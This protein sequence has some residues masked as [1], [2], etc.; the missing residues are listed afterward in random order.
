MS[1]LLLD[2]VG[3]YRVQYPQAG[4]DLSIAGYS[5][6]Q[7]KSELASQYRELA[8]ATVQVAGNVVT[9]ALPSGQKN[10]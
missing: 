3:T 5:P 8:T 7:I 9:F 6:N 2:A 4:L 10:G 1:N